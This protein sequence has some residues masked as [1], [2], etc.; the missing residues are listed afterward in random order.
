MYGDPCNLLELV[1][2]AT[3]PLAFGC[4]QYVHDSD[5]YSQLA[6]LVAFNDQAA[7]RLK[8]ADKGSAQWRNE[9]VQF[10]Y[11]EFI[12]DG[13]DGF[14][15]L[16]RAMLEDQCGIAPEL[17]KEDINRCFAG[18]IGLWNAYD[19][20]RAQMKTAPALCLVV[21]ALP[22]EFRAVVRRL[23][24]IIR[25]EVI[26]HT[27]QCNSDLAENENPFLWAMNSAHDEH[28]YKKM[29][30]GQPVESRERPFALVVD[31]VVTRNERRVK[32]SVLLPPHYGELMSSTYVTKVKCNRSFRECLVVGLAG[33]L[34]D[35]KDIRRGQLLVSKN[36]FD[37]ELRKSSTQ[38]G[39]WRAMAKQQGSVVI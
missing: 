3:Q 33:R 28:V 26:R 20:W 17:Q 27:N 8:S 14:G 11:K 18:F 24:C 34:T 22:V 30:D 29:V 38:R 2:K 9:V 32:V 16:K 36:I 21:T 6:K 5:A 35:N 15:L 1:A 25:I 7:L 12:D 13:R 31:G 4:Q 23:S 19:R 10:V 37:A 39:G